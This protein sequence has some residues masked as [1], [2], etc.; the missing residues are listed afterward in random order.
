M[1]KYLLNTTTSI[2]LF[3]GGNL[4]VLPGVPKP[5]SDNDFN[6]GVFEDAVLLGALKV[7]DSLSEVDV[8]LFKPPAKPDI[9]TEVSDNGS[10][11]EELL[12]FVKSQKEKSLA[13]ANKYADNK[14]DVASAPAQTVAPDTPEV[15]TRPPAK[16]TRVR[17]DKDE[18]HPVVD[19]TQG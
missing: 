13:Q 1:A 3:K 11:A 17:V 14:E 18:P 19:S 2:Y 8:G 12:A 16:K 7:F 15:V 9:R 6:S 10:S 4:E 5:V